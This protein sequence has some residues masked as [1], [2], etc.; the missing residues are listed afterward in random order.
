MPI[1][2]SG[3]DGFN[4]PPGFLT[5]YPEEKIFEEASF[6]SYYFHWDVDK[7][8][9]MPHWE[10]VRWC[11]EIS[12]INKKIMSGNGERSISLLEFL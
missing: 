12:R 4:S 10:R 5:I 3:G 9:D 6:I 8:L 1:L 2:W 11:D 7:I